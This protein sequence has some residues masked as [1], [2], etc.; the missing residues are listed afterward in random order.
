M[1][2]RDHLDIEA[3]RRIG[4][5]V[6]ETLEL[7]KANI[8]DG[9]TTR[10]LDGYYADTGFTI[11]FGSADPEIAKLCDCSRRALRKAIAPA[12]PGQKLNRIGQAIEREAR[13]NSLPPN[14]H[15]IRLHQG[16]ALLGHD[17]VPF[18]HPDGS[19]RSS[20]LNTPSPLDIGTPIHGRGLAHA[21]SGSPA[22]MSS[23]Q[24]EANLNSL[25][26]LSRFPTPPARD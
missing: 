11:D 2:I 9:I 19:P 20:G 13:G 24:L 7:M 1:T 16:E 22:S 8:G 26:P 14:Y 3:L 12:R 23:E 15:G 21:F 5:V 10:E 25:P 17:G 18:P 6:S 4:Q